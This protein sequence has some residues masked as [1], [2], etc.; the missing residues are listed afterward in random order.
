QIPQL[1]VASADDTVVLVLRVLAPPSDA[2]RE[3][4]LAFAVAE[5]LF[6][7]LQPGG[8]DSLEPLQTPAPELFY[9]PDG[10][11]LELAFQP[12]DFVQINQTVSQKMVR[13]ALAWLNL[14]AGER[15]LELFCGLGN[16][17][18]P[19]AAAGAQLTAVEGEQGLVERARA[20]ARRNGL[21]AHFVHADLFQPEAHDPWLAGPWDA[22]LLDPPRAGAEQVLPLVARTQPSRIVYVS[23]NPGTLARDAAM[24]VGQH[25]Y[26]LARVGVL[27]MFPHTA[28]VESMTLFERQASSSPS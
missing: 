14:K 25:G 8:A 11:N 21:D 17:S 26:R 15:V 4:L 22:V 16:F 1:E 20:N 10:S 24:L 7:Y 18:L 28:H 5:G 12:L 19:L 3:K 9:S 6:F 23:C 27:D 13:Q 2:D